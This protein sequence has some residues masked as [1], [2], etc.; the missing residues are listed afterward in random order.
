[1]ENQQ[2][3]CVKVEAHANRMLLPSPIS[4]GICLIPKCPQEGGALM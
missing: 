3:T 2:V 1:M 4:T